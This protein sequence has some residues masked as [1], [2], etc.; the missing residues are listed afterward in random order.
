MFNAIKISGYKGIADLEIFKIPRILLI[1]GKNNVGKSSVL[2]A[3]FMTLDRMNP[4]LLSRHLSF[5]GVAGVPL[6]PDSWW[7]PIFSNYDL[8]KPIEICL[9]DSRSKS[10]RF[11]VSHDPKFTAYNVQQ[12]SVAQQI[13]PKTTSASTATPVQALHISANYN[14]RS[15]QDS[16][17]LIQQQGFV[18]QVKHAE[19]LSFPGIYL[20][21]TTRS[22]PRED[23][24][25]FGQLD[26]DNKTGQILE[27]AQLIEPR[28]TGL[29]VIALG[30]VAEI[31]A[32]VQGLPRKVPISLMG[33][34]VGRILSIT[35]S[36]FSCS[37]G[38]VLVDE[39]ENGLHH[40]K[41]AGFW[42]AITNA[43]IAANCQLIA[44]THNYECLSAASKSSAEIDKTCFAYVR[45]DRRKGNEKIVPVQ[46]SGDELAAALTSEFEVR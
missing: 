2:E 43:C 4:D 45:L 40:S 19:G 17:L 13:P 20:S 1:G 16:H 9:T 6:T 38:I 14:N 28:I 26:L 11:R 12:P 31:H 42:T 33:D 32:T 44:T 23:A 7:R 39:I 10:L 35:L 15:I 5:R 25:R 37:G 22:S 29:S 46:Y 21:S 36:L 3:I 30:E 18:F 41:L 8:S 24:S 34:G 27:V